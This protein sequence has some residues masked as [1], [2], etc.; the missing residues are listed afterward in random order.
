MN[1]LKWRTLLTSVLCLPLLGACASIQPT[2][3]VQNEDAQ[4][5][6]TTKADSSVDARDVESAESADPAKAFAL[7]AHER[8]TAASIPIKRPYAAAALTY[9]QME[10]IS[11]FADS[12]RYDGLLYAVN[13]SGNQPYLFAINKRGALIEKWTIDAANR[14]WEELDNIALDGHNYLIIGDTGDNLRNQPTASL[15]FLPE[16]EIPKKSD[17][18]KPAFTLTFSYEDGPRNVEAFSTSGRSLLLLSKEPVGSRGRSR[19]GIYRLQLPE[20]PDLISKGDVLIADRVGTMALRRGTVES[21]LAAKF[22]DVDLSHPTAM[23]I[24][25]N[26]TIAYILTYREVLSVQRQTDQSWEE[27]LSKPAKRL[28][29]HPLRQAEAMTLSDE[30]ALWLT[31]EGRGSELWT[32]STVPVPP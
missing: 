28:F 2:P 11:G 7:S 24:S 32:I 6:N 15:H 17:H 23:S 4:L 10:E 30:Q 18:L 14:D 8:S 22:K 21:T 9:P 16:P 20:K 26:D 31:S 13:D 3:P 27:A 1:T 12:Q 29:S 19:S 25:R 5:A